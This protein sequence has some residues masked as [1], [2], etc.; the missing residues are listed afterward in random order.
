M[1]YKSL[2]L[3]SCT[4][5]LMMNVAH[6]RPPHKEQKEYIEQKEQTEDKAKPSK[7]SQ[8]K[9]KNE[10]PQIQA[11]TFKEKLALLKITVLDEDGKPIKGSLVKV[12]F[13]DGSELKKKTNSSGNVRFR[14]IEVKGQI[15]VYA[16]ASGKETHF[17]RVKL[18]PGGADGRKWEEAFEYRLKSD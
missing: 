4:W 18:K 3:I 17:A 7:L 6:A 1:I 13:E 15:K 5:L 8:K 9:K 12:D 16:S 11:D 10:N 2:F 14:N